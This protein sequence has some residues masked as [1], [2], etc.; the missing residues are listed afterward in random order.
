MAGWEWQYYIQ[1]MIRNKPKRRKKGEI[2]KIEIEN[3][4][5]I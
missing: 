3:Y 5:I 1:K 4:F 2:S